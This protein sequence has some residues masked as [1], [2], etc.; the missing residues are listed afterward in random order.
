MTT[1]HTRALVTGATGFIGA[2]VARELLRQ[3]YAV[4]ALVRRDSDLRNLRDIEVEIAV[5]DLTDRE[6]LE[7]ALEGCDVLF[8]VAASYTFWTPRPEEMYR[9]NVQGT[10]DILAAAL[11]AGV[12]RVVYTS[13]ESTIG[14]ERNGS[15][16]DETGIPDLHKLPCHYKKSKYQAEQIALQMC[17]QGLH[18]VVVNPT[19]PI[20]TLDIKPTPTGQLVVDFLNHRMPAYVNTGLNIV[21]VEDVARGHILALENG[22]PGER[23]VLGNRNMMLKEVLRMLESISNVRASRTRIPI[24][25]ALAAAYGD[26]FF[27]GRLMRR[28]PR[29]TSASV[30]VASHFRYFDCSKAVRELGMPQTPVEEAFGKAVVWFRQNG[31]AS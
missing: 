26:E 5:G 21:H 17:Q 13:T 15:L 29:V 28:K 6:S 27:A 12:E 3:N 25:L 16:G 4:R 14:I 23:Y 9:T 24:A 19:T 10:A 8:H 31:Y 2:N 22:R 1:K 30:R 20:G 7:R 18:V 11:K